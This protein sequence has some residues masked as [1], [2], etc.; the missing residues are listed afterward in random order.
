MRV[1]QRAIGYPDYQSL[2]DCFS[3]MILE[4][5]D[6]QVISI[7]LY[8]SVAQGDA[9]PESDVDILLVMKEASPI[10]CRR[11]QPLIVLMRQLRK[12]PC[13]KELEAR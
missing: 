1:V 8:G 10:Y 9:G 5:S 3:T 13:W 7:V 12:Q 6:E 4:T 2:L 11:L